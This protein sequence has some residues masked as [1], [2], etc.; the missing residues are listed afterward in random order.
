MTTNDSLT[1]VTIGLCGRTGLLCLILSAAVIASPATDETL[2]PDAV[3]FKTLVSFNGPNGAYPIAVVQGTD[4]NVYRI[5]GSNGITGPGGANGGG[6][7][8]SMS[9]EGSMTVLYNFCAQPNCA[10]GWSPNWLTLGVNG[11]FYGAALGGG[12][13]SNGTI[14]RV[15]SRGTL[16]TV[17]SFC[18]LINCADGSFP[19]GGLI[20]ATD[21]NL[22]GTTV[23][24]RRK[25]RH[26]LQS[27]PRGCLDHSV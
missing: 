4:G 11:D 23:S 6:T 5:T 19:Y 17:Y 2:S 16:T 12:A 10:D 21:G 26:S 3:T 25:Q 14:F 22:Y 9:P 27:H 8:F 18:A 15:T 1:T 7:F 13:Y 24:G 20:Q